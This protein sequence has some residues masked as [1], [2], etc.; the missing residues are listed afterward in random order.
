MKT[1]TYEQLI[2]QSFQG[3][4]QA[5]SKLFIKSPFNAAINAFY[6][7][8]NHCNSHYI[9]MKLQQHL[10]GTTATN[11]SLIQMRE[12][13][14]N[15]IELKGYAYN[16]DRSD[17]L[18][19]LYTFLITI[20]YTLNG[21]NILSMT[22]DICNN[23]DGNII[24]ID[25]GEIAVGFF[26]RIVY[27]IIQSMDKPSL[28]IQLSV[29][30]NAVLVLMA[31]LTLNFAVQSLIGAVWAYT[32]VSHNVCTYLILFLSFFCIFLRLYL[33]FI[34]LAQYAK[35]HMQYAQTNSLKSIR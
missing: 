20:D 34:V 31:R 2:N 3:A 16:M 25:G 35:I 29:E 26:V 6:A 15:C 27:C 4:K 17:P 23:V 11:F 13:N 19:I 18:K 14:V 1:E 7:K 24:T 21:I 28:N 32:Q 22:T 33:L 5:V 12:S 8:Q 9:T 10:I 30:F